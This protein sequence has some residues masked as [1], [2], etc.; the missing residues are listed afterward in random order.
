MLW[1]KPT[2]EIFVAYRYYNR[3]NVWEVY[4]DTFEG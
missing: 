2:K 1:Y 4:P 3:T